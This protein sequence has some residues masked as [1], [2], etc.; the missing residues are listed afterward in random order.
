MLVSERHC[1]GCQAPLPNRVKIEGRWRNIQ[2]RKFCLDCS[3]FQRHN[4]RPDGPRKQI[5][6]DR[7]PAWRHYAKKALAKA[8]RRK[9]ELI[10]LSGGA[11]RERLEPAQTRFV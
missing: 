5:V 2:S 6:L 7:R 8:R 11:C 4:T 1:R 9:L 3:P 10:E